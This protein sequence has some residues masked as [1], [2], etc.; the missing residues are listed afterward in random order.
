MHAGTQHLKR[1]QSWL[2]VTGGGLVAGAGLGLLAAGSAM[3]CRGLFGACTPMSR[4]ESLFERYG[5]GITSGIY[6]HTAQAA[7]EA[8]H[9]AGKYIEDVVAE[10]SDDSFPCS[11]PPA[12]TARG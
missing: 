12:W 3:L 9:P 7:K 10:A 6:D 5:A 8:R 2:W 1:T 4:S 11:D